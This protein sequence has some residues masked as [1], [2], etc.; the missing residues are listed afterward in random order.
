VLPTGRQAAVGAGNDP[1]MF[2]NALQ[3]G[4]EWASVDTRQIAWRANKDGSIDI[5]P[6]NQHTNIKPV[7]AK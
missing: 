5:L 7:R 4:R 3:A 2:A 1:E 6:L